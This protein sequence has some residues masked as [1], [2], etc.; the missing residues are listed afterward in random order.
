M[1]VSDEAIFEAME[2]INPLKALGPY[3]MQA[4][5]YNKLELQV[6][7]FAKRYD[8]SLIMVIC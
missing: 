8:L 2:E 6:N 4:N 7:L 1:E 5:F 3:G